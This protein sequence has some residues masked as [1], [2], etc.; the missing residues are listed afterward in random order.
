MQLRAQEFKARAA[1]SLDNAHLRKAL[2]NLRQRMVFG[3]VAAVAELD[4]FEH[5]REAAKQVRDEALDSLDFLLEE[6]ERNATARG[7]RVHW[8]ETP[9]D[10]NRI[11]LEIAQRAGVRKA[12]KSKS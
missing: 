8:A 9:Q 1:Q 12:I 4:N 5:S 2:S 3:R 7:A 6:F 11:V 10:M